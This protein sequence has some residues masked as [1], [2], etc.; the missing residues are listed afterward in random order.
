MAVKWPS[1]RLTEQGEMAARMGDLDWKATP[2]GAAAT[3][4]D[5]LRTA[6]EICLG[7]RFPI[8]IFWGDK[9][10]QFY[11][12]AYRPILG[13]HKHPQFIG[14]PAKGC[15]PEIWDTVGPMLH[16]VLVSGEATWSEDLPLPMIR[17]GFLEEAY[18]TFSYSPVADG[19]VVG[20]VFCAVQETTEQVL[21]RRR[22]MTLRDLSANAANRPGVG[23]RL[24]QVLAESPDV[25]FALLLDLPV[26]QPVQVAEHAGLRAWTAI[27]SALAA[28]AR[29]ASATG[30]PIEIEVEPDLAH[31]LGAESWANP[32]KLAQLIPLGSQ[33]AEGAMVLALGVSSSLPFDATYRHFFGLVGTHVA[34]SL[35]MARAFDEDRRRLEAMAELDR[36][37]TTFF[38]N[39]SHE[40]RTPLTLLLGPLADLQERLGNDLDPADRALL[41]IAHRNAQRL[42]RLVNGLLDFARIEA[43]QMTASPWSVDLADHT[44]ATASMF[45][46]AFDAAGVE[47]V[48]DCAPL[49]RPVIVDPEM[50]EKVV[51]NLLSNAFK[52]TLD[53]TVEIRLRE[54]RLTGEAELTVSDTGVG[55]PEHELPHLFDRFYRVEGA[56]GRSLEG[57]GIGLALVEALVKLHGGT[58]SV[59]SREAQGTT[60]VVR[61]P[62]VA[63]PADY[64]TAGPAPVYVASVAPVFVEEAMRWLPD[65][66]ADGPGPTALQYSENGA[67]AGRTDG[68]RILIAEDNADLREYLVRLLGHRWTVDRASDGHQALEAV[69]A[70]LPD[71]VIADVM[72]PR[73]DGLELVRA[74]RADES[75]E[76][77]PVVLLSAR[78]GEEAR[79][80]GLEAGADDYLVKPFSS[81]ELVATIAARLEISQA[82]EASR[83]AVEQA[84]QNLYHLLM[85]A[86]VPFCTLRGP[87]LIFEIVNEPYYAV[88]GLHDVVG[89][90]LVDVMPEVE[91]YGFPTLLRNVMETGEPHIGLETRIEFQHPD[92]I[93]VEYM[94]FIYAPM[95]DRDDRIDGVLVVASVVTQ[96]VLARGAMQD[97]LDAQAEHTRVL[98]FQRG[99]LQRANA[100]K[101]EFLGLVSHE[102][103]TPITTIFGNAELLRKHSDHLD[104]PTRDALVGDISAE[105]DRLHRIIENLLVL[106]RGTQGTLDSEPVLV[107]RV[108]Q[109]VVTEHNKTFPSRDVRVDLSG[110][111]AVVEAT[112]IQIE[113]VL[114][115]LISNAEKYSES[116]RPI[117]VSVRAV[118]GDVEVEVGDRGIGFSAVD[119]SNAFTPFCRSTEAEAVAAGVGIGLVVCKRIVESLG[120][121]MRIGRREGGGAIVCFSLPSISLGNEDDIKANVTR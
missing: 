119:E 23:E 8:M 110:G 41:A 29:L 108:V 55:V 24:M 36:A 28:A 70:H 80:E 54:D 34:A 117:D 73:M 112:T 15:W 79:I 22:L 107:D 56:G 74:L 7:S 103:R 31:M 65:A 44:I 93:E 83:N 92:G 50:W 35:A 18:F 6:V 11:N 76:R 82:R 90:R 69:R 111:E 49:T 87:D 20:G 89:R 27:P 60:F 19:S 68:A 47:F 94:N 62:L 115:N 120:G 26:D 85:Q 63:A 75:T 42:L 81:R 97:A 43:G 121:S 86:P 12:D 78:A 46:S 116:D 72:M 14:Q 4:P 114:R 113:Q 66:D 77:L 21:G 5:A 57:S 39:V 33:S 109:R 118:D 38:S 52:F 106:A 104:L 71:L 51:L 32:P 88:T 30:V 37:K 102:L 100:A 59:S 10:V 17:N 13:E 40:F 91:A 3:W 25:P 67:G 16:Q 98:E 45:Q 48:I 53:G 64:A 9:L 105:A 58:I 84:R 96:E 101:D 2:V 1:A 61:I 95:R 99:E